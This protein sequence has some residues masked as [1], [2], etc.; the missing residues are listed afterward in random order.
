MNTM[1]PRSMLFLAF[2]FAIFIGE[3][4]NGRADVTDEAKSVR[5]VLEDQAAAWNRKDLD[6]F[7]EGYWKSPDLVFQSGG[8]RANGFEAMRERYRKRYQGE[9]KAMGALT[10]KDLEVI[11][12]A[13]DAAMVRGGWSLVMPDKSNPH[14]L[15]T[16]ILRKLPEGWRIV[17]DHTSSAS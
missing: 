15:F 2:A 17:H 13:K 12:L 16:V 4:L 8:D 14:G 3:P 7:C 11:L 9:G 1:N 6:G 10:F 5:K